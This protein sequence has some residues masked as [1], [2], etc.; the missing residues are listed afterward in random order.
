MGD[1]RAPKQMP[2]LRLESPSLESNSNR[3]YFK[4]LWIHVG[5]LFILHWNFAPSSKWLFSSDVAP[6]WAHLIVTWETQIR[7]RTPFNKSSHVVIVKHPWESS[8]RN[9][10]CRDAVDRYKVC[11]SH[12][13]QTCLTGEQLTK[14]DFTSAVHLY[15]K[16]YRTK[17]FFQK[18][19]SNIA[20]Q[21]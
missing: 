20:R 21:N 7:K 13:L 3:S 12:Y 2:G 6:S 5:H 10:S 4:F 16:Q 18:N 8:L 14:Q 11:T 17:L 9:T 15:E 19:F 1:G